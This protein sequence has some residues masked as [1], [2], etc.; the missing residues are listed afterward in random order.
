MADPFH[1][2]FNIDLPIE[3][4]QKRFINRTE[5][6]VSLILADLESLAYDDV[7]LD[8]I[9]IFVEAELGEPHLTYVLNS[10]VFVEVW[11]KGIGGDIH[12]CLQAI[13][14]LYQVLGD[15]HKE[16]ETLSNAVD[17]ALA[18]SEVDLGISWKN[19][20]FLKKGA[21][22]LDESLVNEPLRWLGDPAY[23]N[24]LAPFQ[25][26]LKHFLEG[27]KEPERLADSIT[28]MYEATEALAKIVTNKP[29][30]DLSALREDF[31]SKLDLSELYKKMLREYIDYGCEFRHAIEQGKS[32]S[33]PAPH[34]A[35]AFVY[36]TGLFIRLAVEAMKS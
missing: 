8:N 27:A 20:I 31:I 11:R 5:N 32:R 19:G 16:Q 35:E 24:V 30:K 34:E 1:V 10:G 15:R 9:M 29:T 33:W 36:L 2:R 17:I 6:Y 28:D 26:G 21:A 12:R 13:E 3:E 23:Q 25:K 14:G 4:A 22:L 18:K 7:D